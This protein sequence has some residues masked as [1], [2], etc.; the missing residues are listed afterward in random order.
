MLFSAADL[1]AHWSI[2]GALKSILMAEEIE[3]VLIFHE[4]M[5]ESSAVSD[6]K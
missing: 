5:L 1:M 2:S 3:M 6:Y 4:K